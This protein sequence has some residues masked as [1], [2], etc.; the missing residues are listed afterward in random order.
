MRT[1]LRLAVLT[2]GLAVSA[3]P[4]S[5]KLHVRGHRAH[6]PGLGAGSAAA[7][8]TQIEYN[9]GALIHETKVVL[10]QWG[11]ASSYASKLPA[12]YGG[13]LQS[14][15]MD[16]LRDYDQPGYAV[17]RGSFLG[18][19]VDPS[20]PAK[21]TVDDA[22][23]VQPELEKLVADGV[24]PPPDANTLYVI[25]FAP[26]ILITQ[27]G[28]PSCSSSSQN[29]YCAFHGNIRSGS[30][31]IRYAVIPDMAPA[32]C[33]Q[34]CGIGNSSDAFVAATGSAS[35]E[36]LE[37]ITDPDGT[38]GWYDNSCDEIA[39]MCENETTPGSAAG[40]TVQLV[41]SKKQAACVDHDPS[42]T[43]TDYALALAP[44]MVFGAAGQSAT[45]TVTSTPVPGDPPGTLGLTI[46]G[47]PSG[48]TAAFSP[49]S[50]ST[51]GTSTLTFTVAASVADQAYPFTVTG[52]S[53]ADNVLHAITGTLTV[54][55]QGPP[56]LATPPDAST[57]GN[58]SDG[59]GDYG[60]VGGVG[61][62]SVANNGNGCACSF[63]SARSTSPGASVAL[64]LACL[65]F[66]ARRR[67]LRS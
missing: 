39:D 63:G 59:G 21:T 46:A 41:W 33:A 30:A 5:A 40:Y 25:H 18:V 28:D 55:G 10:V 42:V 13:I 49:A 20:P 60:S 22:S 12:F 52:A 7:N 27:A 15:Y 54:G 19:Y 34:G 4:A 47:L 66:F 64:L 23:D 24:V 35:H 3:G 2:I 53:T 26:G 14:P 62:G 45:A 16:W 56:D 38:S 36:I 1:W 65:V 29:A 61:G 67:A 37:A 11:A 17:V 43:V 50:I 51:S 32:G 48:I 8:C 44:P 57:H 6:L 9:G 31:M 58:G